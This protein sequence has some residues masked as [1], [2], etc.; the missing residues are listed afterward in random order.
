MT[1]ESARARAAKGELLPVYVVA[2]DE[3]LLR[4]E[5]VHAL[6]EASLSSGLAELNEDKLSAGE[7]PA[8]KVVAA[9]QTLPM[10]AARR[11]VLVRNAERWDSGGGGDEGDDVAS[12]TKENP[13]DVL[14]A[15]AENPNP[16]TTLVIVATKLDGR[17]RL[18]ALAKKK[19]FLVSCEAL[20]GRALPGWIAERAKASGHAMSRDVAELLAEIAGPEL[21]HVADA[22]ERLGLY[23]GAGAAID[24]D[25]VA[26]CV[27]RVRLADTWALV[28]AI[29]RRALGPALRMLAEAYDPRDRGLPLL[30]AIAW[31]VRQLLKYTLAIESGARDDEA[32]KRAGVFQPMRARELAQ[33]ARGLSAREVERWL[34]VLAQADLALKGS[35]L[36]PEAVLEDAI[37]KL[38][39]R[40]AA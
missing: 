3:R 14:C 29:G 2:G 24:E 37:T 21:G 9:C 22:I 8:E 31:S 39:R 15:Y 17:R 30:G 20:D 38:C 28:D 5:V 11:F 33:K 26:E 4:D 40:A 23:V 27:A 32:A 1:P 34:V 12:R 7:T 18:A 16:T 35:R 36:P 10:M 25:A 13:L 6:R 19:D